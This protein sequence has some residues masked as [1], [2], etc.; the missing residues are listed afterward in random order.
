LAPQ[1]VGRFDWNNDLTDLILDINDTVTKAAD[2]K[3]R[4]VIL[5][6]L[7]RALTA[8]ESG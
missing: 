8:E 7:R 1:A 4:A 3:S 2:E 5:R 6:R